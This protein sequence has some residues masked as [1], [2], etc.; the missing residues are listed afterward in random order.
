MRHYKTN[1][2]KSIKQS[3]A[4]HFN[5]IFLENKL[6]L[7]K[8]WQGIREIINVNK[9]KSKEVNCIQ[10]S[11]KTVNDPS[12]IAKEFNNHFTSIA[13]KLEEKLIKPKSDFSQYLKDPNQQS[14]F[15]AAAESSEILSEI[16][17]LKS[18]KSSGPSGIPVKILKLFPDA[19]T[20]PVKL[21]TNL[22]FATGS[23]PSTLKQANVI[24]IF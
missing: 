19:F 22:S 15:I 21:I 23:F 16:K 1:I 18:S 6:N 9:T 24:A 17:S 13:K 4:K 10:V 5:N 8:T 2:T 20:E 12:K 3:K 7:Y 11:N 14:F